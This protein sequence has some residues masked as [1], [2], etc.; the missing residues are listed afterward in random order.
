LETGDFLNDRRDKHVWIKWIE[1]RANNEAEAIETPTG[2]IPKY[3]DLK[4]LFREVRDK[5]YTKEDYIRQFT[6]RV[7]ENLAKIER[8]EK[9]YKD[10]VTDTPAEVLKVLDKQ[11]GRLIKAR[12]SYGDYVSPESFEG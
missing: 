11:R 2:W 12:E 7:P 3:D 4:R 5:E 1:M 6:I 10:N 9:F 8:V